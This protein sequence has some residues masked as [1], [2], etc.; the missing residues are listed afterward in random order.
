M[1]GLRVRVIDEG[2][3][4]VL[5]VVADSLSEA[6]LLDLV[7]VPEAHLERMMMMIVNSYSFFSSARLDVVIS[8]H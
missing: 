3:V 7:S 2:I 6:E 1:R 4:H 5:E 8:S